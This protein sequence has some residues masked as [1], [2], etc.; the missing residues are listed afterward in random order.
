AVRGD[1]NAATLAQRGKAAAWLILGQFDRL[2][3]GAP[4]RKSYLLR[5]RDTYRQ[6]ER[7][8]Q[9]DEAVYSGLAWCSILL[10][11]WGEARAP[12]AD[13]AR[14]NPTNPTYPALQGLVAWLDSTRFDDAPLTNE[15]DSAYARAI[16]EAL[17]HYTHVIELTSQQRSQAYAT[18]SVLYY[19]L[20]NV[21]R[22]AVYSDS[23]YGEWMQQ[24][25][26]DM[27]QALVLAGD[28]QLSE[29]E[30]VGY[31]YWRGRLSFS[32]AL[33]WQRRLRGLH[34]WDELV[35]LYSQAYGDFRTA[36]AHD[37]NGRRLSEYDSLRIPWTAYMLNNAQHMQ[38]AQRLIRAGD[39]ARARD[40]LELVVPILTTQQKRDW[41]A[42]GE[43]NPD[44]SLFH[45]LIMLGL[46]EPADFANPL[47]DGPPSAEAS[48][49]RAIRDAD[50]NAI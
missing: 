4:D 43:P 49:E 10:D 33:T 48:I 20:R 21:G 46:G 22:G 42:L 5:A 12:L 39:F 18:R 41:D 19:S 13:A 32:L 27:N 30:Q 23:D 11:G 1:D 15:P 34:S 35:P 31:H 7:S 9:Q 29:A 37:P 24:A 25:I 26:G 6:L 44:Y 45:A 36:V 17:D 3:E 16:L 50:N 28:E 40:E 47:L 38:Q 14:L 8:G 2:P